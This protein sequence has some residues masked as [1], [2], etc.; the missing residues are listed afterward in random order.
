MKVGVSPLWHGERALAAY[1]WHDDEDYRSHTGIY[2]EVAPHDGALLIYL[3][4]NVGASYWDLRKL[5]ETIRTVRRRLGGTFRSDHGTSRYFPL[6][7]RIP[8][9]NESGCELAFER[10]ELAISRAEMYVAT[11]LFPNDFKETPFVDILSAYSPWVLSNNLLLP[12]IVSAVEEY[13]RATF[14]ALLKYSPKKE[15]IFKSA[16]LNAEQLM[17]VSSGETSVEEAVAEG[18]SFQN[19]RSVSELLRGLVSELDVHGLLRR[20]Y[21]RRRTSLWESL[22]TLIDQRHEFV[23]RS[24]VHA[25]LDDASLARAMVDAQIAV[26]RVYRRLCAI[27]SWPEPYRHVY[28]R[29]KMHFTEDA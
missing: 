29:P 24:E 14:V 6:P 22:T 23:H 21:R 27:S 13:F 5:N 28:R 18:F 11:R 10:F 9:P 15:G 1:S 3:R 12:Y 8:N 16:R 7:N 4:S 20:P 2:A 26:D 25:G 17:R 19:L